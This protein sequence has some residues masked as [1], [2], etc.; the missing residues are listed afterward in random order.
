M[1]TFLITVGAVVLGLVIFSV[2]RQQYYAEVCHSEARARMA[3]HGFIS[4]EFENAREKQAC[5]IAG[6]E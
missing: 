2:G 5:E 1:K 6:I 3:A 4:P